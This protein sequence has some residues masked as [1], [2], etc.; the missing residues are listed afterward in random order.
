MQTQRIYERAEGMCIGYKGGADGKELAAFLRLKAE[1]AGFCSLDER[2]GMDEAANHHMV[3]SQVH[4]LLATILELE[5]L[6]VAKETIHAAV[7]DVREMHADSPLIARMQTWPRGYAGD[8]ETVEMI[9]SGRCVSQKGT[10]A[11]HLERYVLDCPASQQHRNKVAVQ[12]NL[13]R[14]T[15]TENPEAAILVVACGGC[16]DLRMLFD[17]LKTFRGQL[18]LN[19]IDKEALESSAGRIAQVLPHVK[20]EP[21]NVVELLR[22]AKSLPRFDL[23]VAGGL[24]DYLDDRVARFVIKG[25]Y[26]CLRPRGRFF[27]TNI[28]SNP[29]RPW[30]EYC[31]E[32]FLR[33]RDAET[34]R[35]L[36]IE[37]GVPAQNIRLST[38]TTG[39][40][41][42]IELAN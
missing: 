11:Y 13:I 1:T 20:S 26:S 16:P 28:G 21:G 9:L 30:M 41:N 19:D 18:W 14:S 23:I 2:F 37:S 32:W 17:E 27:F 7:T 33:E 10:L 35:S 42:L 12:A 8:Y 24:F 36:V 4:S 34:L 40:T 22:G 6:G 15:M 38:E 3:V 39:L 5:S 25:A 31:G 29:Y